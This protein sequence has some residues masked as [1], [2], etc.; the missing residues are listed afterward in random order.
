MTWHRY[1]HVH[2]ELQVLLD[3]MINS[4]SVVGRSIEELSKIILELS[5]DRELHSPVP[6]RR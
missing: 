4:E 2:I 6:A 1:R 3:G 5:L